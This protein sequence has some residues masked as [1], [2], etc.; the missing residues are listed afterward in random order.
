MKGKNKKLK[1]DAFYG[2]DSKGVERAIL[3]LTNAE[4]CPNP[5]AME[6]FYGLMGLYIDKNSPILRSTKKDENG[7]EHN[8]FDF[9]N[10]KMIFS[11]YELANYMKLTNGGK[12]Y[13]RLKEAIKEL[14]SLD[15][16][17]LESGM[18]YDKS[19]EEFLINTEK[20]IKLINSYQFI[21]TKS[22]VSET[23]NC[24]VEFGSLIMEN[25]S[26]SYFKFL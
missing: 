1:A 19:K 22:L 2:T 11:L 21:D 24:N 8:F 12:N 14:H 26:N 25:L 15:I 9:S 4:F 16:Y 7:I 17:S 18:F 13:T 10:T 3:I 23:N 6:V 5:F 20:A